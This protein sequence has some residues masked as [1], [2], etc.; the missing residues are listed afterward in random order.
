MLYQYFRLA[1]F[2]AHATTALIFLATAFNTSCTTTLTAAFHSTLNDP[3]F[4]RPSYPINFV[5]A[6]LPCP[7]PVPQT[8]MGFPVVPHDASW[9]AAQQAPPFNEFAE[10]IQSLT[11]GS[12]WNVLVLILMF[13]WITASYA[14]L[15]LEEPAIVWANF[16]VPP[17][18]HPVPFTA[19]LWNVL[20]LVLLWLYRKTFL[21]PDNNLLLFSF[22]LGVTV[23][24]Q[25]Y[26]ARSVDYSA[27]PALATANGA[28]I[29]A[30]SEARVSVNEPFVWRTDTFLRQRPS[31]T[32]ALSRTQTKYAPLLGAN[33]QP[34]SPLHQ[35]DYATNLDLKGEAVTARMME[36]TCTAPLLIVGLYLN[37][38]TN[39]LTWTYQL[40]FASLCACN[41]IGIPL[42]LAMLM[43]KTAAPADRPKLQLA[44]CL[45][46]AASWLAF[47]AG[48]TIYIVTASFVLTNGDSGAPTWV[49]G[50]LWVVLVFYSLFGVVIT[51]YYVPRLVNPTPD[52]AKTGEREPWFETFDNVVFW[53]DVLSMVTKL[54]VA[55]TV[56]SKGS[57][58][59]C[60]EA[61]CI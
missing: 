36:Y 12:S 19:T 9:C 56:Y 6:P 14:L 42:H 61:T 13:E 26:I 43:L 16:P 18:V 44:A 7:P 17:G 8:T 28:M 47:A 24:L 38:S 49:A 27:A 30:P 45:M 1:I 4:D 55:W 33:V 52:A 60:L 48:F 58:V 46:L 22:L 59:N 21:L 35:K 40:I 20:L 5:G 10:D 54:T 31:S 11:I 34:E 39:A 32:T 41:A 53:L 3:P 50:L 15:Y 57:V 23:I 37:F 29:S 25:N 2:I 51:L